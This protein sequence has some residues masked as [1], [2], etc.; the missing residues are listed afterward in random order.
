M[1]SGYGAKNASPQRNPYPDEDRAAANFR[2]RTT[3]S[4]GK[5]SS[6]IPANPPTPPSY[7]RVN[8]V[9]DAESIL[10]GLA[11]GW[12]FWDK[13]LKNHF[14][15]KLRT[16]LLPIEEEHRLNQLLAQIALITNAD[17]VLL[18]AFH[19]GEIDANGFHLAKL[20]TIN[21][22]LA[23]NATPMRKPIQNLPVDKIVVE[24]EAMIKAEKTED[25]WVTIKIDPSFPQPCIDHLR[26]DKIAT[27]INRLVRAGN[28][29]IGILSIQYHTN[30][31][32]ISALDYESQRKLLEDC[33]REIGLVMRHR[34]VD[35]GLIQRLLNSRIGDSNRMG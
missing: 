33:Y 26:N 16:L 3:M 35:P 32:A 30:D 19:N 22:Y 12:F 24:I 31:R 29:P 1:A 9:F 10:L 5:H 14:F 11:L 21:S 18:C 25:P 20:S 13:L 28:L 6:Q 8:I 7:A 17:R 23:P 2:G 4:T 15:K 34:I 27:M